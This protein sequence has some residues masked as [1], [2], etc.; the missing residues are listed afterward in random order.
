MSFSISV[1]KSL[2]FCVI[3]G[4]VPLL[5]ACGDSA[6]VEPTPDAAEPSPT[7]DGGGN[8]RSDADAYKPKPNVDASVDLRASEQC[9]PTGFCRQPLSFYGAPSRIFP[10]SSKAI[11]VQTEDRVLL[12]D[13]ETLSVELTANSL[14]AS[15]GWSSG[16]I[17]G[18]GPE[19]TWAVFN[20]NSETLI[21]HRT[22]RGT[23][24]SWKKVSA[25]Y[26]SIYTSITGTGPGGTWIDAARLVGEDSTGAL[27]LDVAS[28]SG[29]SR[30]YSWGGQVLPLSPTNVWL[31]GSRNR[32]GASS[33]AHWNGTTWT[34]TAN[35]VFPGI[36]SSSDGS[37]AEEE[38][39]TLEGGSGYEDATGTHLLVKTLYSETVRIDV[40]VGSEALTSFQQ[41][42]G[43]GCGSSV[44]TLDGDVWCRSY[45]PFIGEGDGMVHAVGANC[46]PVSPS[47]D[48]TTKIG[49]LSAL[50][51]SPEGDIWIAGVD[52]VGSGF[53]SVHRK[54]GTP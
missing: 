1:A 25:S 42:T 18:S 27:M 3:S 2:T 33:L 4:F 16:G 53:L 34:I 51:A 28:P 23:D 26:T 44:A 36:V 7:G 14:G 39:F 21:A 24:L 40:P 20:G 31:V 46:V 17:A 11:F 15:S 41:L 12:W 5:G 45:D 19:D 43:Y 10:A 50:A 47:V 22:R 6:T 38:L 32:D 29:T 49:Q 54:A 8:T 37:V 35:V 52:N 13:G 9:G 30:A 48:G